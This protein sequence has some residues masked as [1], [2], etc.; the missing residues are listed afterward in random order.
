MALKTSTAYSFHSLLN[1]FE[2]KALLSNTILYYEGEVNH[3]I[4]KALTLTTEKH[5]AKNSEKR[6]IQK[7]V[8]NVMIE[9]LQNIDKHT[10]EQDVA[11]NNLS[12]KGAILVSD[13]KDSYC[14]ISGNSVTKKQMNGLIATINNLKNRKKEELRSLYKIQLE[15]GRLSDKGGAG[16]GFIDMARK[17]GNA[18]NFSFIDLENNL[19]FFVLKIIINKSI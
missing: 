7:K 3:E 11:K 15:N 12:K 6:M 1:K 4:T 9:C 14:I 18:L 16:L 17:T 8:F 2:P 13:F 19:F 5:L 10:V